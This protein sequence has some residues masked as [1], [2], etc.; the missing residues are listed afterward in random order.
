MSNAHNHRMNTLYT[1]FAGRVKFIFVN[2]N[3]NES[4]VEVREHARA[5]EFDF[6]VFKDVD[7]RVAD[8][9]GAQATPDMFVLD[10][11]ETIRYHGYIDDAPNPERVKNRC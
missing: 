8:L 9:F 3:S 6:P 10:S 2:S 7:N 4:V 1:E 5:A 11:S